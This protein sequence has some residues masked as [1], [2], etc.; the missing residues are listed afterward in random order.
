MRR[1]QGSDRAEGLLL[2]SQGGHHAGDKEGEGSEV[3]TS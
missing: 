2:S 3:P 1:T